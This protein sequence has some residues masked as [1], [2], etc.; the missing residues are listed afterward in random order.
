MFRLSSSTFRCGPL[1]FLKLTLRLLI[2]G[3][4][5]ECKL[6]IWRDVAQC[7]KSQV[8]DARISVVV[9]DSKH[10]AVWVARMVHK[11][12]DRAIFASINNVWLSGLAIFIFWE[13]IQGKK[14]TCF[15]NFCLFTLLSCGV[16]DNLTQVAVYIL[17]CLDCI[18]GAKT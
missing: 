5:V 10:L 13:E 3:V 6:G 8:I 4:I 11:A 14:V 17:T 12:G 16:V 15:T 18:W 9:G 1:H 7:K 2:V